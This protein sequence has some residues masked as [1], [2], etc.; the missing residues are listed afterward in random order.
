MADPIKPATR[1]EVAHLVKTGTYSFFEH[2]LIA[3]L[4]SWEPIVKAAAEESNQEAC[5]DPDCENYHCGAAKL[6]E[7]WN[8]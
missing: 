1:V 3:T 6:M 7:Q 8:A 4:E 2:A 5:V